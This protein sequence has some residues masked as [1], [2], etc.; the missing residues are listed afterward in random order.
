MEQDNKNKTIKED[1]KEDKKKQKVSSGKPKEN[2]IHNN[3]A[4]D[5][6]SNNLLKR[7]E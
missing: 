3:D 5:D 7:I 4:N 6:K 2:I 1:I